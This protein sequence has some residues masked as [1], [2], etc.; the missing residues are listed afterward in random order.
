M[1]NKNRKTSHRTEPVERRTLFDRIVIQSPKRTRQTQQGWDAFFPYYAGYPET[2]ARTLLESAHLPKDAAVLD[3]WNGSGTTTFSASNLGLASWGFDLNPIMI[4]VA[5]ARLLP[6]SE[7]DSIEPLTREMM[8]GLRTDT[9]ILAA[10]DPLLGWFNR[11]AAAILRAIERR[12]CDHLIGE[13]TLTSDGVKLENISGLAASFYVALFS[14]CRELTARFRSS[15]PTWLCM[16]KQG[17]RRVTA[18][19]EKILSALRASL[20]SMAIALSQR[21][22]SQFEYGAVELKIADTTKAIVPASSIDFVLTSPPY[23]TRIDYSAATRIELALLYP[24]LSL[25]MEELGRR[26]IGSTRVPDHDIGVQESWGAT[27]G[28]FLAQLRAHPSKASAGYYYK[29]HLDYFEKMA[30]S[31]INVSMALKPKGA[32]ILVVQDS[33]YK[34]IHN[35]LPCITVEIAASAGLRLRRRADFR[36]KR[37]MAGINPHSRMYNRPSGA[38]EAVLCFEKA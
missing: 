9:R 5:R 3:P 30:S 1:K 26:M 32:A 8:K 10:D 22:A 27:C 6:P 21:S 17:E 38:L 31:M 2:F 33:F 15:N 4:I 11:P 29:T 19:R 12:I 18:D 34:D 7:A 25:K 35:D 16:P 20:K 37:S 23:C 36:L 24:L 13:R 28:R 14:V